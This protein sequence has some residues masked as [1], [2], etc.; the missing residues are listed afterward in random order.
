MIDVLQ[1]ALALVPGNYLKQRRMF[2]GKIMN[3]REKS[4]KYLQGT[5]ALA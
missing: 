2:V 3:L 4:T 1:Y 5:N